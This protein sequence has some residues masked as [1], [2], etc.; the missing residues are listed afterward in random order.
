MP[1]DWSFGG[2]RGHKLGRMFKKVAKMSKIRTQWFSFLRCRSKTDCIAWEWRSTDA[3]CSSVA[4]FVSVVPDADYVTGVRDCGGYLADQAWLTCHVLNP[5]TNLTSSK[6]TQLAIPDA[7]NHP[8]QCLEACRG[9]ADANSN[10]YTTAVHSDN[11]RECWCAK[12]LLLQRP[13]QSRAICESYQLQTFMVVIRTWNTPKINF[14]DPG[15]PDKSCGK[16]RAL[17]GAVPPTSM[18]PS[19]H[20]HHLPVQLP[21]GVQL[22]AGTCSDQRRR[23]MGA[24]LWEARLAGSHLQ[25]SLGLARPWHRGPCPIEQRRDGDS[26]WSLKL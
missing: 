23:E 17:W 11:P 21:G 4:S 13:Y 16:G 12:D 14:C 8:L 5:T 24:E 26:P 22:V 20:L 1:G 25:P 2:N 9:A 6:K 15:V 18:L 10:A 7:L 3:T 19:D